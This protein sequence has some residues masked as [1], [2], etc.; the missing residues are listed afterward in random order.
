MKILVALSISSDIY[1]DIRLDTGKDAVSIPLDAL[2]ISP[3]DKQ[4]LAKALSA[5]AEVSAVSVCPAEGERAL[6]HALALG[7]PS[8]LRINNCPLDVYGAAKDVSDFLKEHPA[9][10][11]LCGQAGWDYASGEFPGYL[12]ELS[13]IGLLEDVSDFSVSGDKL[14]VTRQT[15]A[16]QEQLRVKTPVILACTKAIYPEEQIRIPSM[17]EM[18][19]SM[20]SPLPVRE[21]DENIFPKRTYR[22]YRMMPPRDA[23]RF[24]PANDYTTL[25]G[26]LRD[27]L[28]RKDRDAENKNISLFSGRILAESESSGIPKSLPAEAELLREEILPAHKDL[29]VAPV[30]VSGGMGVNPEAWKTIEKLAEFTGA[31]IGCTR[32][33]YQAGIRPYFEHVG[34]TGA[35]VAPRLYVAAGISGALQHI[36][37]MVRSEKVL[38]INSDPGAEIFKYADYG[39]VGDAGQILSG[40]CEVLKS[41]P[42]K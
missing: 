6:R 1:S 26:I 37:G 16:R 33:V 19:L 41:V 36:A 34:Q 25:A 2:F 12:S 7:V 29:H 18:M 23:V 40:I 10:V 4:I 13:G 30:I 22:H 31:A 24:F 9:D 28:E 32:P 20:R 3:L 11:V 14:Y 42:R 39:V 27:A 21:G 5:D 8:V 38:A 15:D 35:K 17:R